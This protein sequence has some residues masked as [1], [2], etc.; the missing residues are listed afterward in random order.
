VARLLCFLALLGGA[1][2]LPA[3]TAAAAGPPL[4]DATWVTEV[5]ATSARLRAEINPQGLPTTYRFEYIALT[6]YEANVKA[7][8]DPFTGASRQPLSGAV[9]IGSGEAPVEVFQSASKLSPATAYRYRVVAT[10]SAETATGPERSLGTE[11][12]TNVFNLLDN[13]GW[14]MVSPLDKNGGEIQAPEGIFGGGTFQA[15]ANG[16]SLTYSSADSFAGGQGAPPGSQYIA[17]R[18]GSGWSTQNITAPLQSGGYGDQP[19]GVPYQ[20]FSTDLARGVML[21]PNRCGEGEACPRG[22]SLRQGSGLTPLAQAPGLRFEGASPDLGQVVLSSP[23][24]LQKWS[25]G[26][27][28]PISATPGAALAAPSGAIST[29]GGR[30]YFTQGGDLYLRQGGE[31]VR[32][33]EAQGGGGAFQAASEDGRFAFFTKSGHLYR[34]DAESEAAE[35]LTPSG[36]VKGVLGVS[37]DGSVAYYQDA[38][39]LFLW[40]EGNTTEAAEGANAAAPSDYPPAT[41]TSRVNSDGAHLLFLSTAE[42]SG[43]ENNGAMEAFLYGPP[44][45]GG[46]ARLACVSCNPT[47]ER[48]EGGSSIPGALANGQGPAATRAY[49][50]RV[51]SASGHRVFFNSEDDLAPQDSNKGEPDVYE[52]EAQGEGSCTREGG[53]VG[54]ISS[55]RDGEASTFIDASGDGADAFFLTAASLAF[56]D[57]GSYDLYDARVGGGFPAPPNFISC[58]ADACQPL[59]EA[60]EDPTPGTLVP[61]AGNP[62][63]RFTKVRDK[64]KHK[65]KKNK[66]HKHHHKKPGGKK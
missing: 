34:W 21:D 5:T 44:P 7:A 18:S 35:D 1:L 27:L 19:E 57:P 46:K 59:P 31:S 2:A 63:P 47:G 43:Y 38:S 39:G 58:V 36:G 65:P 22:Y 33:D 29:D 28:D 15:A 10:N 30:V 9:S 42:L 60:P 24:G 48:P 49:L 3:S 25:E 52:W 8:K 16:Q 55:G 54:L 51:L 37:S 45:G 64:G 13:R 4:I 11:E 56:G 41:G 26:S 32:V 14:E 40:E 17:T 23:A 53:C 20:L 12:A 66:K 62:A 50:P 6:A 61:N